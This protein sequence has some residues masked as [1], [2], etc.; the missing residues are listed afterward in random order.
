MTLATDPFTLPRTV[1]IVSVEAM[2]LTLRTTA[3]VSG[4]LT[5]TSFV[6]DPTD[7]DRFP[8]IFPVMLNV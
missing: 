2:L 3:I 6:T 4:D 8:V 1:V 5:P 7:P